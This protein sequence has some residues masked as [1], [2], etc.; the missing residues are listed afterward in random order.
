VACLASAWIV[1]AARMDLYHGNRTETVGRELR[2]LAEA[3]VVVLGLGTLGSVLV[4]DRISFDP[5]ATGVSALGLLAFSRVLIRGLLRVLRV[6]GFDNR[7]LVIAGRGRSAAV[8]ADTVQRERHRGMSLLGTVGLPGEQGPPPPGVCELGTLADL[9]RVL[10][11]HNVDVVALCPSEE[12]RS[13]DLLEVLNLC[14]VA[15]IPCHYAPG[16]YSL[17]GLHPRVVRYGSLPSFA[18]R[19]RPWGLGGRVLRR[20]WDIGL[21]SLGFLLLSPVLLVCAIAIRVQDRGRIFVRQPWVGRDGRRFARLKFRILS[22]DS[23]GK[24][25]DGTEEGEEGAPRVPTRSDPRVTPVGQVLR[26]CGVDE[27]PQLLNII[28]GDLSLVGLRP[29]VPAEV[30]HYD[31][32]HRRPIPDPPPSIDGDR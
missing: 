19:A 2:H 21:A 16:F 5:L 24:D 11:D 25:G 12:A 26:W 13:G 1:I 6:R 30:D 20:A 31:W 8:L 29:P 4:A 10:L 28:R 14:E 9:R 15:D 27:L 7:C 32:W 18:F 22:E 17:R 3:S 23:Q